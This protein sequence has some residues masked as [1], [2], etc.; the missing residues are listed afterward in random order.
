MSTA[1]TA[2]AATSSATTTST[3]AEDPTIILSQRLAE[4]IGLIKKGVEFHDDSFILRALRR[5]TLLRKSTA[6]KNTNGNVM[7]SLIVK[8]LSSVTSPSPGEVNQLK[9][10]L[11]SLFPNSMEIVLDETPSAA[12]TGGDVTMTT[13]TTEDATAAVSSSG[14][15]QAENDVGLISVKS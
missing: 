10:S 9:D 12:A 14:K 5:T 2:V 11:T 15:K 13:S 3:K 7:K 6:T 4:N 1:T 8:Y